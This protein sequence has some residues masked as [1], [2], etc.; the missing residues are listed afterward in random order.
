MID[1]VEAVRRMWS[2]LGASLE[3]D[4]TVELEEH[5]EVCKR[6]CGELEFSRH[7]RDLAATSS[8]PPIRDEFRDRVTKLLAAGHD[9]GAAR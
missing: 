1:C 5:L 2:Y 9:R 3:P 4:P 8:E 7:V 6:C